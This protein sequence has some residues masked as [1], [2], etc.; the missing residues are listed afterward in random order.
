MEGVGFADDSH[1]SLVFL[2]PVQL[3][4]DL[5]PGYRT[6]LAPLRIF[7][8]VGELSLQGV[9]GFAFVQVMLGASMD[10]CQVRGI[11]MH[12]RGDR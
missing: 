6:P 2:V 11:V 3:H 10:L 9:G 4:L 8:V 7:T 5:L 12:E 1:Q